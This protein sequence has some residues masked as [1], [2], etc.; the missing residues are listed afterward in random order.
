MFNSRMRQHVFSVQ[1]LYREKNSD[2]FH[3]YATNVHWYNK[4]SHS[5]SKS[6]CKMLNTVYVCKKLPAHI[7]YI[8]E[9]F[10]AHNN[11]LKMCLGFP[12]PHP[13]TWAVFLRST[14]ENLIKHLWT[15]NYDLLLYR[16]GWRPTACMCPFATFVPGAK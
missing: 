14:R 4:F 6:L 9:Y 15:T 12:F 3:H 16:G 8:P 1:W 2:V 13:I 5:F 10:L 11:E 7:L